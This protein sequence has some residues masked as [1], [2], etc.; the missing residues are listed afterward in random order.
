VV[1]RLP[2]PAI[3]SLQLVDEVVSERQ[4]GLNAGFF[5]SV[6][7][8]WRVRVQAYIDARGAPA[9]VPTWPEIAHK[10]KSFLNLYLSPSAGSAQGAM[11]EVLRNHD[12]MICPA[13]GEAGRPNTL[14]HY[15]PKGKYPHFCVT[16]INLF[17]MCDACQAEKLEKTG[18]SED[19]RFFLHPY[20]DVFIAEQVLI[21]TIHPPFDAPT[22]DLSPAAGLTPDQTQLVARHVR[23]LAI[24]QRYAH[25][26]R[27]QHRRLLRLVRKMRV[28]DQVVAETLETFRS[29]LEHPSKNCWEH[30]FYTAVLATSDFVTYLEEA[31]LPAYP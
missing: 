30:I 17:P 27:E 22:F 4:N 28:S 24:S 8:D 15:L 19:P 31:E 26:F 7:A 29:G 6:A 10:K 13:C 9:A 5:A 16:P 3:C 11:I 14:D 23:E 12:L 1:M 18:D 20:F 25:F 2:T 21:L